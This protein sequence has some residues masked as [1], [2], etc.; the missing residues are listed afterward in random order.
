MNGEEP[1]AAVDA[2]LPS[3]ASVRVRV[4]EGPGGGMG[5][6]GLVDAADLEEAMADFVPPPGAVWRLPPSARR[7][8]SGRIGHNDLCPINTV[9]ANG[10]PYGFIDWDLAGPAR[11]L[12][13]IP[14]AAYSFVFL[15]PD[16]FWPRPGCPAPPDRPARLR[17]FCD[18][19][20]VDDRLTLL[21]AVEGAPAGGAL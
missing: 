15:R 2:E 17:L 21:D 10:R 6:V 12:E 20:G 9:Y 5:S 18:A 7:P 3:G 11:D 14:Y 16:S 1:P 19:Y 8:P 4:A 13:D